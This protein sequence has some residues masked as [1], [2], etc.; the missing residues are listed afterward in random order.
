MQTHD[1]SVGF[2]DIKPVPEFFPFPWHLVWAALAVLLIAL[3]IYYVRTRQAKQSTAPHV[4]LP[5][6]EASLQALDALERRREAGTVTVR[7]FASEAS[8]VVRGYLE[9]QFQFPAREQTV[10]EATDALAP[11]LRKQLPTVPGE[12]LTE[13]QYKLR[14]LLRTFE[15]MTFSEHAETSFSLEA[16]AVADHIRRAREAIRELAFY[17]TKERERTRSIVEE[18]R[19]PEAGS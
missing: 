13:L 6:D 2:H 11:R 10:T 5:P 1:P 16:E 3:A 19:T 9:D 12:T 14:H 15:K 7:A 8:L 18:A 17:V 4:A